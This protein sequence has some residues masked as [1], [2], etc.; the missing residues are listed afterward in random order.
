L[1]LAA[2]ENR[3]I[4]MGPSND[5]ELATAREIDKLSV[6]EELSPD[7]VP[8]ILAFLDFKIAATDREFLDRYLQWRTQNPIVK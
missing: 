2:K 4:A 5:H 3:Y 8:E 7:V 6:R 1:A